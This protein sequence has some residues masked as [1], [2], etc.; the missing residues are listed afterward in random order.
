MHTIKVMDAASSALADLDGPSL[1]EVKALLQEK[2]AELVVKDA[3]ILSY[4]AEI[5][6]LRLLIRKLRLM[7]FGKRSEKRAHDIEQL[8]LLVENLETAAAEGSC[9][10]A[11][12]SG[13]KPAASI[14][15][16]FPHISRAKRR[17]SHR[18]TTTVLAAVAN[19]S[20]WV[21]TSARCSNSSRCVLR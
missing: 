1:A 14:P 13:I 21:M 4:T 3:Q 2:H 7:Q 8:E 5:E 19:S 16:P 9:M 18:R 12:R 6:S 11:Q 15:K 20:I 17:R 10:L